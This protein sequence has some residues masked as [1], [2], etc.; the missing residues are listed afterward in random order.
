[1]VA[2]TINGDRIAGNT[3]SGQKILAGSI[4][5]DRLLIPAFGSSL[6]MDPNM[7]DP[8]AWTL[9]SGRVPTFTTVTDGKVGNTVARTSYDSTNAVYEKAWVYGAKRIPIDPSK[10]YRVRAWMRRVSG[11]G[12]VAYMGVAL[13]DANGGDIASTGAGSTH[14]YYAA[15][16]VT[17]TTTWTEYTGSFGAGS[18]AGRVFPDNARTMAPLFI[19]SYDGTGNEVQ[20]IQ[21][22]RIEEVLPGTL[23][24]DGTISTEKINTNGL[25]ANVIKTGTLDADRIGVGSITT[26]KIGAGEVKANNIG[27][28]QVNAQHLQISN[29]AESDANGIFMD[30]TNKK[31]LIKNAGVVRVKIGFLG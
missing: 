23:I 21:D 13:F 18:P 3:L 10:T 11:S 2:D 28:D 4:T 8:T 1:M 7:A 30:G 14:W 6:N 12:K 31:I 19:L 26:G 27:A 5:A 24:K 20:E 15:N 29:D 9:Y 16:A 22:L 17:L 25:N